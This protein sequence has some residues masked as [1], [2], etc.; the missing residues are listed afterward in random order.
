MEE[1]SVNSLLGRLGLTEYEAK[2]LVALMKSKETEAPDIS[3]LAQVPKTRVYDVLDRL[4]KRKLVIEIFGRPKK[5]R[6]V[7]AKDV[8]NLLL[9]QKHDELNELEETANELVQSFESAEEIDESLEKVMKV[10]DR[11]DFLR[12]LGQ[13]IDSAQEQVVAFT[14]LDKEHGILKES[15]KKARGK[16][17]NVKVLSSVPKEVAAVAKELSD[18]GVELKDLDHG[19]HAYVIDG[20]KVIMALS[21]FRR[22]KPEYHFTIWPNNK[23]MA[24]VLGHYFEK[25]WQTA[26]KPKH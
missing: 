12:I 2:T 15:L 22:E 19:M 21:D 3:R 26:E 25:C 14:H 24:N 13:E 4:I 8:F 23:Q 18:S 7:D 9:K 6:V 20:K 5:Y 1:A 16:K 10:K 17:V 11:H